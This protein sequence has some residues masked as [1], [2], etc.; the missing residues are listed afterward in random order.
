MD[1]V[2]TAISLMVVPEGPTAR[3]HRPWMSVV[4]V[5]LELLSWI[6]TSAV[7]AQ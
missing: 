5:F 1:T 4:K 7:L 2:N 3:K 6:T